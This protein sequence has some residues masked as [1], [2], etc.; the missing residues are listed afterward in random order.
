MLPDVLMMALAALA[1]LSFFSWLLI[2]GRSARVWWVPQSK[3]R[4]MLMVLA[5]L[6]IWSV[7]L[8]LLWRGNLHLVLPGLAVDFLF[9]GSAA[10][11]I[12]RRIP[13]RVRVWPLSALVI[14][15]GSSLLLPLL[16]QFGI[17]LSAVLT[18]SYFVVVLFVFKYMKPAS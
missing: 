12:F 6:V 5:S 3:M 9:A 8:Q 16:P 2:R 14:A 4:I 11:V 13:R 17:L 18:A 10:Y 1:W 7:L 15:V